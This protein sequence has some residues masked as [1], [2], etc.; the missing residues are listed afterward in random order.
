MLDNHLLMRLWYQFFLFVYFWS[1]WNCLILRIQDENCTLTFGATLTC[2][3]C[4]LRVNLYV[5]C[6]T[7]ITDWRQPALKG[8]CQA[9]CASQPFC[10]SSDMF[11]DPWIEVLSRPGHFTSSQHRREALQGSSF[12][13]EMFSASTCTAG[14]TDWFLLTS[15]TCHL[16]SEMVPELSENKIRVR[17]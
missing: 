10:H 3:P 5:H 15:F 11:C 6:I 12:V 16:D 4:R 13:P 7:W 17:N 9:K 1:L 8:T 2:K 14:G